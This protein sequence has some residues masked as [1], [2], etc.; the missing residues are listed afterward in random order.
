LARELFAVFSKDGT[1]PGFGR[2]LSLALRVLPQRHPNKRAAASTARW[3]FCQVIEKLCSGLINSNGFHAGHYI[4]NFSSRS[5]F[6]L[7]SGGPDTDGDEFVIN[8]KTAKQIGLT[9]PQSVLF[10]A[11]KVIKWKKAI[12]NRQ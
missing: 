9:I 2:S 6:V 3:L 12:G 4:S 7:H 11:D 10:R 1:V 8:L 5:S